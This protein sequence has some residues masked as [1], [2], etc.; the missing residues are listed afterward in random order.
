MNVQKTRTTILTHVW[1]YL[2][3]VHWM[4]IFQMW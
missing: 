1:M 2:V 4:Y 3:G